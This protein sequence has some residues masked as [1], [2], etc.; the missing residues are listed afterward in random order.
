MDHSGCLSRPW[1]PFLNGSVS[2]LYV[3]ALSSSAGC[4]LGLTSLYH[5]FL[6]KVGF[7]RAEPMALL[8][9][10]VSTIAYDSAWPADGL[11]N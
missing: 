10:T 4:L 3:L 6:K 5:T 11:L 1:A 7:W 8:F 9:V 2:D